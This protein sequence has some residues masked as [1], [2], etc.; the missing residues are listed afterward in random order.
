M[1]RFLPAFNKMHPVAMISAY[2]LAKSK[3]QHTVHALVWLC[4]VALS[5]LEARAVT[6][7]PG[8][9]ASL[10]AAI[11]ATPSGGVVRITNSSLMIS[12]NLTLNNSLTL[13]SVP[14]GALIN[15]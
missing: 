3:L 4:F 2:M 8:S 15:G 7:Y 13:R 12:E 14:A 9:F 5:I 6:Y 10:Q 1:P 11:N